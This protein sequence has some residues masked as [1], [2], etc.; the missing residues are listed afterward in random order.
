MNELR[1][2]IDGVRRHPLV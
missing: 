2:I 1:K